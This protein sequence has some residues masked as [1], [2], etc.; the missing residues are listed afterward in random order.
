MTAAMLFYSIELQTLET[1]FSFIPYASNNSFVQ[2]P[3]N[4][5]FCFHFSNEKTHMSTNKLGGI[6]IERDFL[7]QEIIAFGKS[8]LTRARPNQ[9]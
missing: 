5:S 8:Q 2:L 7:S 9:T 3:E 1:C 6:M 4:K